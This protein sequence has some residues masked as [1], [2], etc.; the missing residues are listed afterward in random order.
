MAFDSYEREDAEDDK[1]IEYREIDF[2]SLSLG[3]V[4]GTG[5]VATAD[6]FHRLKEEV[7]GKKEDEE[8]GA[9]AIEA[10]DAA[11][12]N[13]NLFLSEDLEGLDDELNEL[14]IDK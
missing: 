9:E 2:N 6:R 12:I 13:E 7:D 4:D 3:E 5:T 14:D 1:G 8:E 11:P 10:S